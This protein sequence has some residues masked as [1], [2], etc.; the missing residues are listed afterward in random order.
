MATIN[1]DPLAGRA[2]KPEENGGRRQ[3]ARARPQGVARVDEA[4]QRL[5]LRAALRAETVHGGVRH[6]I[7]DDRRSEVGRGH[8]EPDVVKREAAHVTGIDAICGRCAD[9]KILAGDLRNFTGGLLRRATAFVDDVNVLKADL[10][11]EFILDAVDDD[12]RSRLARTELLRPRQVFVL[13]P[14]SRY[15]GTDAV[16]GDV[17][18]YALC[19][20]RGP[21]RAAAA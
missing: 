5:G 14:L 21:A 18:N 9:F 6:L 16:E 3:D 20:R 2:F 19:R 8:F 7:E 11:Q 10:F 17:A 13:S 15:C 1:G 12:A 4:Q